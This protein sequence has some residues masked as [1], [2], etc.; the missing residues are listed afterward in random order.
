MPSTDC[1]DGYRLAH[2]FRTGCALRNPRKHDAGFL[3]ALH[4]IMSFP[5]SYARHNTTMPLKRY[6]NEIPSRFFDKALNSAYE[7]H[8]KFGPVK[9][10]NEP[11]FVRELI[12]TATINH[13]NL[14][15][16][17]VYDHSSNMVYF[18]GGYLHARPYASFKA[19]APNGPKQCRR[20]LAD[21]L[22]VVYVTAPLVPGAPPQVIRRT[23][24]MVMFKRESIIPPRTPSYKPKVDPLP[25]ADANKKF[26]GDGD[27]EQFYLFNEWPDFSLE[28][29][30][31]KNPVKLGTFQFATSHDIGKFGLVWDGMPGSKWKI[32]RKPKAWLFADPMPSKTIGL[33]G[34][35]PTSGSLGFLLEEMIDSNAGSGRNFSITTPQTRQG[36]WDDLMSMLLG[37]PAT[38]PS[39]TATWD[40]GFLQQQ[41]NYYGA[42]RNINPARV[43]LMPALGPA[44]DVISL[45]S[46]AFFDASRTILT[47][48]NAV[49]EHE[50]NGP[51]IEYYLPALDDWTNIPFTS[52]PL[53][54]GET[55]Y[56]PVLIAT[57]HKHA[58]SG[59]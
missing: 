28:V 24:C 37:Y 20:E 43:Q 17:R 31:L 18:R 16:A 22:I 15:S 38:S 8:Y 7:R 6:N 44:L 40:P 3:A 50:S 13:L 46:A 34:N 56:L 14:A 35:E 25:L 23:A 33:Q 27:K 59:D 39:G 58:Q 54:D 19:Q 2:L 48:L 4:L 55:E 42:G 9:Q 11:G 12:S 45:Q 52:D 5:R 49:R 53:D 30:H 10:Q 29:G 32:D 26:T 21:A 47:P 41:G 1:D 36:N 57:V 51:K